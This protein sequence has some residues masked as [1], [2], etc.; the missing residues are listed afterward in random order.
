MRMKNPCH[1]GQIARTSIEALGLTVTEA[2]EQLGVSR[3]ALSYV[4]NGKASVSPE[5]AVRFE[6]GIGGTA[7]HWLRMQASY[8][9][10]Q[11]QKVAGRIRVRKLEPT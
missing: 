6:K 4:L 5:M 3:R 8:D 9:A 7:G 2:A 11:V 1:P 10:A